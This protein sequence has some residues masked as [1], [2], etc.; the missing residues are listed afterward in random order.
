MARMRAVASAAGSG[1]FGA[2]EQETS[3]ATAAARR[4]RRDCLIPPL[5]AHRPLTFQDRFERGRRLLRQVIRLFI[6]RILPACDI[7][8]KCLHCA[9]NGRAHVGVAP[10]EL[11][12]MPQAEIENVV[13]DQYLD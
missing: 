7:G 13:E 3:T 12:G 11:G 9:S 10:D 1:A 6:R 2:A 4:P 8:T 5:A